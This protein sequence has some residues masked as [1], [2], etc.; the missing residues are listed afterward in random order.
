L[1]RS[2]IATAGP[3]ESPIESLA[4]VFPLCSWCGPRLRRKR[5]SK[6]RAVLDDDRI[7]ERLDAHD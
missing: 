5:N 3:D 7:P 4:R 6:R 1:G 2:A